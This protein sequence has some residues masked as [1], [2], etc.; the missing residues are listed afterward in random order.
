MNKDDI[1]YETIL[2]LINDIFVKADDDI[3]KS[4]FENYKIKKIKNKL[5][6]KDTLIYS[7]EYTKNKK[8]KIDII[9]MEY[10]CMIN[11]FLIYFLNMCF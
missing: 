4:I 10:L 5:S 1:N 7:L 11:F 9:G 3:N 8:T 2:K 6:F